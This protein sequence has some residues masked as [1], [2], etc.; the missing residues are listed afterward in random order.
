MHYS[1]IP[2]LICFAGF[3]KIFTQA[4][5]IHFLLNPVTAAIIL[6][7]INMFTSE[8]AAFSFLTLCNLGGNL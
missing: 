4:L 6:L 8:I 5:L 7:F 3:N 2:P 1:K